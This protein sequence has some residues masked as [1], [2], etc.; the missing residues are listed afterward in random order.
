MDR[1][2]A[3]LAL[4]TLPLHLQKQ[5][6]SEVRLGVAFRTSPDARR[7]ATAVAA[8]LARE[9]ER[10]VLVVCG[11]RSTREY[12]NALSARLASSSVLVSQL[13][14]AAPATQEAVREIKTAA[15]HQRP[16]LVVAV[17]G[18][19]VIDS[20]KAATWEEGP[21]VCIVPTALSSDSLC[22]PVAVI[23]NESRR[24]HRRPARMPCAIVVDTS[25]TRVAP[26]TLSIAGC[27]D[28]LSNASALLD[29]SLAS[30][31]NAGVD[32]EAAMLSEAAYLVAAS[33][34]PLQLATT[35]GQASLAR[36]LLLSGLAMKLAGNTIP[37][38]GTEHAV[39]HALDLL[40]GFDIPHGIQVGICTLYCHSLRQL[41]DQRPLPPQVTRRLRSFGKQLQ[42]RE[43]RI[44]R[45][46]FIA[47]VAA[48]PSI[49]AD[50]PSILD[51]A[52]APGVAQQ[53]YE[54]A[55]SQKGGSQ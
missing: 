5:V 20:C 40:Y 19:T 12:A 25:V 52:A 48:A 22:S 6:S 9:S 38:S 7:A 17:G 26:L 2:N 15:R 35:S 45:E 41:L 13:I 24:G 36:A 4:M 51:L 34:P 49:R 29:S 44:S 53:A 37:C 33:L 47:A 32:E 55:F 8:L 42:P 50:R 43:W 46:Q 31:E 30:H 23:R 3:R 28:V 14:L 54:L 10:R 16:S 39:S 1:F 27:C 21:D 11:P 18:G